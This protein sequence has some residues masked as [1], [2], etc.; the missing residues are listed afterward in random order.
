MARILITTDLHLT[1]K[2]ADS[3]RWGIFKYLKKLILNNSVDYLFILG[4]LTT[5]KD[6]HLGSLVNNLVDGLVEISKNTK[7]IILKGNHD[8][9]EDEDLPFFGFLDSIPNIR[10]ITNPTS[11]NI[12]GKEFYFIPHSRV[13]L[14]DRKDVS[15]T[16][17]YDSD[18]ILM[19]D[20]FTGVFSSNNQIME[21][22]DL[23]FLFDNTTGLCVSG[24]IHKPQEC[25]GVGS[26]LI[27]IGTPYQINYNDNFSGRAMLVDTYLKDFWFIDSDDYFI[28]KYSIKSHANSVMDCLKEIN[29]KKGD[30]IKILVNVSRE[31]EG[32]WPSIRMEVIKYLDKRG[33][34][35]HQLGLKAGIKQ[36]GNVLKVDS[37]NKKDRLFGEKDILKSFSSRAALSK[38]Y[39][40]I[41]EKLIDEVKKT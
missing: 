34:V 36:P 16:A 30:K 25:E 23:D 39:T 7:I 21:G 5:F 33:V 14:E 8:Y 2:L 3:Y 37:A 1:S 26:N 4:D 17:L 6:A 18:Y 19:H 28:T 27:Y 11:F 15:K 32:Y 20:T 35:V 29:F 31:E 22:S 12:D 13:V 40:I 24:D 41:A 38:Q 9:N 10:F